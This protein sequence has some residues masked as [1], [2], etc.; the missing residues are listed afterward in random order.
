MSVLIE[1]QHAQFLLLIQQRLHRFKYTLNN[2]VHVTAGMAVDEQRVV[3]QVLRRSPVVLIVILV[4]ART[5]YKYV[6]QSYDFCITLK[7]NIAKNSRTY[8][9]ILGILG[10]NGD[11]LVRFLQD[12]KRKRGRF[13][14]ICVPLHT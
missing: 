10:R 4:A 14:I 1:E 9:E 11:F 6:V 12:L 3:C 13:W 2:L 8:W 5:F 7:M